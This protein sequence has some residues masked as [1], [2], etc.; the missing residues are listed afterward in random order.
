[1]PVPDYSVPAGLISITPAGWQT[2][3][4][5]LDA[6]FRALF[7]LVGG[8]ASALNSWFFGSGRLAGEDYTANRIA[9]PS[10]P[11]NAFKVPNARYLINGAFVDVDEGAGFLIVGDVPEEAG[12]YHV[13]ASLD[14]DGAFF[15]DPDTA[16]ETEYAD[17]PTRAYL[18]TVT[19]N[20]SE[21]TGVSGANSDYLQPLKTLQ[22]RFT[23]GG[24]GE[25]V[26]L[27]AIYARLADLERRIVAL[28]ENEAGDVTSVPT[29]TESLHLE[30]MLM[31]SYLCEQFPALAR[32]IQT[33]I[34]VPGS[35]GD[36][37]PLPDGA[38]RRVKAGGNAER[39]F[40]AKAIV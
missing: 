7:A 1:M 11:S 38:A 25:G 21:V 36:R 18:G 31:Q 19:T 12:T 29:S 17:D 10:S 16:Y 23:S 4:E 24:G 5:D 3:P 22:K 34:D 33:A 13:Y 20:G 39:D 40:R 9:A 6:N 14:E 15:V 37:E 26:D 30:V 28:E 8:G 27:S 35:T 2:L 32:I